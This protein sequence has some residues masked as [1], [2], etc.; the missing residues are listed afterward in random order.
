MI[1][2]SISYSKKVPGTAEYSSDGFLCAIE[3]EVS[4]SAVSNPQEL[5]ERMA[6][7]WGE[8]RRSVED[9]ISQNGN[10]HRSAPV[11]R[12][13][14]EQKPDVSATPRQIKFLISLAQRDH[15]MKIADLKAYLKQTVGEEDPHKLGKSQASRAIESLVNGGGR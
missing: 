10:G 12:P 8:S 6:W 11:T 2:I 13:Q 14:T 5:R 4:D 9:Q 1:K 7:L 3:A 15:K